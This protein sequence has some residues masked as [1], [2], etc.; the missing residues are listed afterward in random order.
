MLSMLCFMLSL[1]LDHEACHGVAIERR[2]EAQKSMILV[3]HVD[4]VVT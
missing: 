2:L 3:L 1:M 4:I